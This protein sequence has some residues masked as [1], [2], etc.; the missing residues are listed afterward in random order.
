MLSLCAIILQ[1]LLPVQPMSVQG[2]PE[3]VHSTFHFVVV[4]VD[5]VVLVAFGTQ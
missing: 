3:E 4:I 1:I 5:V 2:T